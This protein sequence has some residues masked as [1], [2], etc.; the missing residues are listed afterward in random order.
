MF[1]T[2][3]NAMITTIT[4]AEST[5]KDDKISMNNKI[6]HNIFKAVVEEIGY[7]IEITKEFFEYCDKENIFNK[8]D[9]CRQAKDV[10]KSST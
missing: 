2:T 5:H 1:V 10:V 7:D 8:F 3:K 4:L 9:M 6:M